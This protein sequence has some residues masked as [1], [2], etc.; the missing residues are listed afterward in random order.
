MTDDNEIRIAVL[1]WT[2]AEMQWAQVAFAA[3]DA[4][5]VGTEASRDYAERRKERNDAKVA[6]LSL[7]MAMLTEEGA[8][9]P[10][11]DPARSPQT[12]DGATTEDEVR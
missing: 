1:R 5:I 3:I 8:T 12:G 7:G 4:N 6:L 9:A 11:K 2:R 10:P